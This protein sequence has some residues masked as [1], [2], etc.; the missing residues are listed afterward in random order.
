M[1]TTDVGRPLTVA[2]PATEIVLADA[3]AGR[4]GPRR[5][6][7][8]GNVATRARV[9]AATVRRG[10]RA[11]SGRNGHVPVIPVSDP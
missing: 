11:G 6:A 7:A 8:A 2:A 5:A 9:A 10:R 3:G 4:V 1:M